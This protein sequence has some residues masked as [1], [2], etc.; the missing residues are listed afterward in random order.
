MCILQAKVREYYKEFNELLYLI[1]IT[2][3]IAC[4]HIDYKICKGAYVWIAMVLTDFDVVHFLSK[5]EMCK[6]SYTIISLRRPSVKQTY[7][8]EKQLQNKCIYWLPF[9]VLIRFVITFRLELNCEI[10]KLI[11]PLGIG[12]LCS[13]RPGVMCNSLVALALNTCSSFVL[14]KAKGERE[15]LFLEP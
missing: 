14:S 1:L 3:W 6:Y 5:I 13:W 8:F 7:N 11:H 10:V 12:K 15:A 4:F 9:P 2:E